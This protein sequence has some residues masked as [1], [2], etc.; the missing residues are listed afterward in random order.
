[1]FESKR[2]MGQNKT[3]TA[4]RAVPRS[5]YR[6]SRRLAAMQPRNSTAYAKLLVLV[7]LSLANGPLF[8]LTLPIQS[9][10]R[11]WLDADA[12][13]L[14]DSTQVAV[15][16]GVPCL[17]AWR[18]QGSGHFDATQSSASRRPSVVSDAVNGRKVIKFDGV[19]DGLSTSL[20]QISGDKSIFVVHKRINLPSPS[21]AEI[22]ASTSGRGWFF[23]NNGGLETQ[24]RIGRAHDAQLPGLPND[25]VL[26][27]YVRSGANAKFGVN[28][29]TANSTAADGASGNYTISDMH[30]F[31]YS[32]AIAEVL[33][34]N[35]AV[36][37]GERQAIENYLS[38]KWA[39]WTVSLPVRDGLE[40]WLPAD[41][42]SLSDTSQV[43]VRNG[44]YYL[45]R[46]QGR[47]SLGR[48]ARQTTTGKQ[49]QVI[50]DGLNNRLTVRFDGTDDLMTTALP[51]IAGNKSIFTV[52]KRTGTSPGLELSSVSNGTSMFLGNNGGA[53]EVKGR[54]GANRTTAVYDLQVPMFP[55]QFVLKNYKRTGTTE[56]LQVNDSTAIANVGYDF[57]A[58][59]YTISDGFRSPFK[60]DI[61]EILIYNR[62]VSSAEST[63]ILDY[64]QNKWSWTSENLYT[65]PGDLILPPLAN[66]TPA[67]GVK[68]RQT[69]AAYAGTNVY[70]SLYLPTD[71]QPDRR[72]PV[73]VEYPPNGPF[74]NIYLDSDSGNVDE[75]SLAY[76]ITGGAGYIIIGM[77]FLGGNPLG[78]H[79][80]WWGDVEA[81]KDYCLKTVLAVCEQ[82]NG[83][84]S[85]VLLAGFS[86][87]SIAC[88][89]IGLNDDNIADTWLAFIPH[90]QYDGQYRWGYEGDD[91]ASA[92]ARL[93]RLKG[94]A[95]HISHEVLIESPENYL[96][97]TG[98]D[99]TNLP[100]RTLPFSNH[101]DQWTMRPI[102]LRRD[103]R[104]WLEQVLA[105]RPGTYS[106]GGRVTN[107]NGTPVPGVRIQSGYTHFTYTGPDGT[108][109]LAGLI[110][111]T[112]TVSVMGA[113]NFPDNIVTIAGANVPNV[114]FQALP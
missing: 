86:R 46:W 87:G 33:I 77:P 80:D 57:A 50:V 48:S 6:P 107:A 34:Y 41:G 56:Q 10:L 2:F 111:S 26:K 97:G 92:Y 40:M 22:S 42:I 70:H 30:D 12:V 82:Y 5:N 109:V 72:Y 39:L 76:G 36:N 105:N 71:W 15:I 63:A 61:A 13:N 29:W 55:N 84:P 7:L 114:N 18:D 37:E 9:G 64:L 51:Q 108:Y 65:V 54:F 103:T 113:P 89:Y 90:S 47:N 60:G 49:P 23:G 20:P 73:I 19:N 21:G 1:M 52:M 28:E 91:P 78:N 98:I 85:A 100:I 17:K 35:R 104:A 27:S 3:E 8:G 106:I 93:L 101:T 81:T 88:N 67:P 62:S 99:M 32:G 94:R 31:P 95:Q 11:L 25:Y 112:R 110:D 14:A 68:V 45:S 102:Q 83:D 75:V 38:E 96:L 4:S 79:M 66:G 74:S 59:Y 44:G 69:T 53:T 43:S 24:G 16:N 58:S